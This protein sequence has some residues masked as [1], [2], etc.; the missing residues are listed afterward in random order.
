MLA[1][2]Y[3]GDVYENGNKVCIKA[4]ALNF[5]MSKGSNCAI[6][7]KFILMPKCS[8]WAL[9]HDYKPNLQVGCI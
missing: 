2:Q 6:C 4:F 3:I 8:N 1:I 9:V 7:T 5:L